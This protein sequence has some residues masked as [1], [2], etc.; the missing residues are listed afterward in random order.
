MTQPSSALTDT[1]ALTDTGSEHLLLVGGGMVGAATACLLAEA[2]YRITLFEQ[3][4][5]TAFDPAQPPDRRVSAI[6]PA[7]VALLQRC[8]AWQAVLAMRACPY[9]RLETWESARFATRFHADELGLSELGFI[10]E[11]RLIQLALWQRLAAFP[12]VTLVTGMGPLQL[13]QTAERVTLHSQDGRHWR[14][15]WLLAADGAH[16]SMRQQAGIGVTEW[17]YPQRCMLINVDTD[18]PQQDITWQAFHPSGPRAFLPLA[19]AHASLVWYDSPA[20]IRAL[21]QLPTAQL[22]AAIRQAFPHEL[23]GFRVTGADSFALTRRH[24]QQYVAGRVVLLGD[25]AHTIHPLA[26]QGV[27]LGF[28]DVATLADLLI[29]AR[30]QGRAITPDLLARYQ[31]QRRRDNLLM[32]SAMDLFCATFSNDLPPLRLLRNLGLGL[33]DRAGPLKRQALRY[34]LGLSSLV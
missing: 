12:Q 28:R 7:A 24:A 11:N 6:S 9:K 2:G 20:R 5:P 1:P 21:Q 4:I 33:A 22:E 30:Q 31:R 29:G 25:A 18:V 14:G 32:Q 10:V 26:G 16:S 19:G 17:D 23:P 13:A 27:N 3:Q 34:A 15:D 8:Q